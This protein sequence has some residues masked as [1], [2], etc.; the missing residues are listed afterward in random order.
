MTSALYDLVKRGTAVSDH[1]WLKSIL[2]Q[3]PLFDR[4][5]DDQRDWLTSS[6]AEC[7]KRQAT[8]TLADFPDS[9]PA[10]IATSLK[11]PAQAVSFAYNNRMKMLY[12][13]QYRNDRIYVSKEA[14]QQIGASVRNHGLSSLLGTFDANEVIVAHEL[15]HF[16][17]E[18]DPGLGVKQIKVRIKVWNLFYQNIN[19]AVADEIAA[20]SFSQKLTGLAFHPRILEVIHMFGTRPDVAAAMVGKA[21]RFMGQP[22]RSSSI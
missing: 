4:F 16:F 3:D 8:A 10:D 19:P 2:S 6:A 1:A 17:E 5:T 20:S 14:L 21:E 11:R 12:M 9:G 18:A 15:F 13:G 7:G 22:S